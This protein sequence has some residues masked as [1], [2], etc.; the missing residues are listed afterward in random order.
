MS[1]LT[2]CN[3]C[4]LKRFRHTAKKRGN[5]IIT[6]PSEFMG[7]GMCVFEVPN[8]KGFTLPPYREP[9]AFY[10]NGD[11]VYQKYSIGWMMSIP[12]KCVC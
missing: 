10:P 12:E 5:K 8:E 11:K 2:P 7:G 6:S 4:N 9:S 3:Y 1:E